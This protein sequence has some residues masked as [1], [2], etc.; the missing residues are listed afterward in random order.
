M[1]ASTTAGLFDLYHD[2]VNPTLRQAVATATEL[3]EMQFRAMT[4]AG[5]AGGGA[6][7]LGDVGGRRHRRGRAAAVLV[8]CGRR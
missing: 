3:R 4:Q 7:A 1:S 6:G 8:H 2:R 5:I